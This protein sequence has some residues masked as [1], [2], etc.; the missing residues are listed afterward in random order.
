MADIAAIPRRVYGAS[1]SVS[2]ADGM[3]AMAAMVG[4]GGRFAPRRRAACRA[5]PRA[6][7]RVAR[8]S[9]ANSEQRLVRQALSRRALL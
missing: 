2:R 6:A 5:A 1:A 7:P 8:L 4:H 3:A 9:S